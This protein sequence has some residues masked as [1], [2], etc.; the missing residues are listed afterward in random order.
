MR[1]IIRAA[2]ADIFDLLL[3][4]IKS[5]GTTIHKENRKWNFVIIQVPKAS[6]EILFELLELNAIIE[7]D[8]KND[9]E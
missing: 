1:V 8:V 9:L 4:K 2:D 7:R 5:S 6:S 3:R